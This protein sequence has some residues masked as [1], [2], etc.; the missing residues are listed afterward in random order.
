MAH[1]QP[2]HAL[3]HGSTMCI[4]LESELSLDDSS[5]YLDQHGITIIEYAQEYECEVQFHA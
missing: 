2:V 4:E 1:R 3:L 5:T